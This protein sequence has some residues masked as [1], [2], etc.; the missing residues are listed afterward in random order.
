MNANIAAYQSLGGPSVGLSLAAVGR[1]APLSHKPVEPLSSNISGESTFQR[2]QHNASPAY[3]LSSIRQTNAVGASSSYSVSDAEEGVSSSNPNRSTGS[4]NETTNNAAAASEQ[5]AP[6]DADSKRQQQEQ[7]LEVAQLAARDRE[8]RAHEQAHAA[9]G[10]Q[11]AGAPSYDYERGPDGVRY[12][13]GGEVSIDVS[14]AATPEETIRKAQVVR[15]AALAPA[16]PSPQD[17]RV[18]AQSVQIEAE[19]QREIR[20]ERSDAQEQSNATREDSATSSEELASAPTG[21]PEPDDSAQAK[22]PFGLAQNNVIS[23]FGSTQTEPLGSNR[24][25]DSGHINSYLD[26]S[27]SAPRSSVGQLFHHTA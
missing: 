20:V 11:H 3:S 13:V 21:L 15:R 2:S 16:E 17:R 1:Y 6:K 12:A 10:G 9:V 4:V 23:S 14:K 27:A 8:V 24:L 26:Y 25:A 19:A 18:A 7:Q 22:Q 5:S